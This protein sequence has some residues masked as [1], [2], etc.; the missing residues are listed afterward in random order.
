VNSRVPPLDRDDIGPDTVAR[1]RSSFPRADKF[2][3]DA[4]APPLPP[5]LGLLARHPG[6][7]GPWLGFSGAL[8]DGGVLSARTRELLILATARRTGASYVWAEHVPMAEVAGL[9]PDDV[10]AIGAN[11][12]QAWGP[13]DLALLRAVDELVDFHRIGDD[14]WR[15]LADH[16]DDQALLEVLFV[17][18]AYSCLAMVLNGAGLVAAQASS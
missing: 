9:A 1:L 11:D 14:T 4:G 2:F 3:A 17:V 7:A 5:V 18:G 16:F 15:V 13:T 10:E 6:I 12:V 8:L